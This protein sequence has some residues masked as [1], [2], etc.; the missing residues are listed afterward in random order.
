[1]KAKCLMNNSKE[2][3]NKLSIKNNNITKLYRIIVKINKLKNK[4][5]HKFKPYKNN[6]E[7]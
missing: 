5:N 2:F 7:L 3:F 4:K 1:M 6:S